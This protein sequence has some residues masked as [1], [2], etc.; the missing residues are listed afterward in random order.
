MIPHIITLALTLLKMCTAAYSQQHCTPKLYHAAS[1]ANI[2]FLKSAFFNGFV[3][4]GEASN[5]GIKLNFVLQILLYPFTCKSIKD[6]FQR[7]N[8]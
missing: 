7:N 5:E 1:G 8:K 4:Q 2:P 6:E 3:L